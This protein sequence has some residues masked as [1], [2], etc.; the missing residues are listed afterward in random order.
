MDKGT[1]K[2]K[3]SKPTQNT[4]WGGVARW[5][6]DLLEQKED[7]YQSKVI[8]PNMMRLVAPEPSMR[9]LD[10]AC[11]QGFFTRAFDE[12]GARVTGVDISAELIAFA[13]KNSSKSVQYKVGSADNLSQF[14]DNSFDAITIVL[15]LQNIEKVHAVFKECARVLAPEGKLFLVLNHP[16]FRIPKGSSW[17]Y[18]EATENQYRRVDTYMS[19]SKIVIDMMP[20]NPGKYTTLSFHRPLQ[21]YVKTLANAGF[22]ITR[23]EEWLS[24]RESERGPRKDAEDRARAEIPIFLFL[25]A[26]K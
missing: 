24:H 5:Y 23:L 17:G 14:P 3:S 6:D 22:A 26:E 15:A 25:S 1:P 2:K 11:G 13:K 12:A 20:S 10:L 4:S 7:T 21:Y 16:A 9:I 8:L 19:E 18:D